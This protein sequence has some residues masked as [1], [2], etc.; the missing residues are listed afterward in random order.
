[1]SAPSPEF[2]AIVYRLWADLEPEDC[3][4]QQEYDWALEYKALPLGIDLWSLIFLRP[5]GEILRISSEPF[6]IKRSRAEENLPLIL[7]IAAE[8]YPVMATLVR[9]DDH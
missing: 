6:E 4:S 3:E 9:K 5:D 2:S 7:N 8:R 1:M